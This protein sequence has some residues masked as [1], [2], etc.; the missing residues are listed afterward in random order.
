MSSIVS[1]FEFI[2]HGGFMMY[3]LLLSALVALTVIFERM[4]FLNTVYRTPKASPKIIF[5][6]P[7]SSA[8]KKSLPSLPSSPPVFRISPTPLK[9]WNWR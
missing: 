4:Y 6:K 2:M 3:P 7:K 8:A 5:K 1:G 9:R